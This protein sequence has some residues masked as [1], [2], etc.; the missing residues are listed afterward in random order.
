M[1]GGTLPESVTPMLLTL[2]VAFTSLVMKDGF[3]GFLKN[4]RHAHVSSG[5]IISVI[6]GGTVRLTQSNLR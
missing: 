5:C 6:F 1:V 3:T 4:Q 2:S